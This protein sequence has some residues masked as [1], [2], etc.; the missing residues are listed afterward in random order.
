MER[1]RQPN[2]ANFELEVKTGAIKKTWQGRWEITSFQ[3]R[4]SLSKSKRSWMIYRRW[5]CWSKYNP[6]GKCLALDT[7]QLSIPLFW[8]PP[9][10]GIYLAVVLT[11]C[12]SFL[13]EPRSISIVW[14]IT[15]ISYP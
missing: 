5:T 12:S 6:S 10:L 13:L 15:R 8:Q 3:F 14:W 11:T 4:P 2:N 9:N 7:G 1:R